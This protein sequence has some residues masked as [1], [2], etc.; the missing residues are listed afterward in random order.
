MVIERPVPIANRVNS[1]LR[2]RIFDGEFAPVGRLPSETELASEFGVSR[3]TVRAALGQLAAEGLVVRRQ[4]DG[5]YVNKRVSQVSSQIGTIWDFKRLIA[6]NGF[7]AT[8][9]AISTDK[10]SATEDEAAALEISPGEDVLSLVRL[11]LADD[12]PVIHS[13]NVIPLSLLCTDGFHF[14]I[15]LPIHEI[16]K[17]HCVQDIG[18]AITKISAS[19][20]SPELANTLRIEPGVSVLHFNEV[21][22]N[23]DEEPLVYANNFCDSRYL[24]LRAVR[25]WA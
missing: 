18:F 3:A 2:Q 9:E 1:I 11:F 4:G 25:S 6:D 13:T 8:I 14:E 12:I 23:T 16:L 10:N 7:T 24:K 19:L 22:Y 21:I 20:V 15:D 5:T 17:Q